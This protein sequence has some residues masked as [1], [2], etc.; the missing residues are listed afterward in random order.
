M[1]K[2]PWFGCIVPFGMEVI[3]SD[4]EGVHDGFADLDALLIE[5]PL[6]TGRPELVIPVLDLST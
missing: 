5:D 4:V 2:V 6:D 1:V 3:A